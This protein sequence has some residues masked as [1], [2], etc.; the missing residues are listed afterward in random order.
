MFAHGK[1]HY[2]RI[3]F[4]EDVSNYRNPITLN[5]I[6][7]KLGHGMK[8]TFEVLITSK[9]GIGYIVS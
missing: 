4:S 2:V 9:F 5:N 7:R 6:P 3:S 1:A 8:R